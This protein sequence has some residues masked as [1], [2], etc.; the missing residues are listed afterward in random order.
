M[1]QW[2]LI[3]IREYRK[4]REE[5]KEERFRSNWHASGRSHTHNEFKKGQW[6]EAANRP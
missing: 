4:H 2:L 5:R 6:I 1:K 3:V